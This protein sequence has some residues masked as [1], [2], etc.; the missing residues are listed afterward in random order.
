MS[1][2]TQS[3]WYTREMNT[4]TTGKHREGKYCPRCH[5]MTFRDREV[6]DHC[7]HRFRTG[8]EEPDLNAPIPDDAALH[9][10]MQFT[11]PPLP[12]RGGPA[13]D[14]IPDVLPPPRPRPRLGIAFAAALLLALLAGLAYF[15]HLK[16]MRPAAPSPAGV[17]ETTLA[18]R[19]D[20]AAH[21]RFDFRADGSG[22]FAWSANSAPP[23]AG[24]TALRWRA[25]PD[26][27]LA[28]TFAP[29]AAP[30]AFSH[31]LITSF[32]SRPWTWHV[33]R[34]RHRLLIGTWEFIEK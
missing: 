4:H 29:P 34:P 16:A 21:L 27:R 9:R 12:M 2:L 10:T 20:A 18:G 3:F 5:T 13:A 8:L 23:L 11:Q 14:I 7:G 17:W 30:D 22:Q 1:T 32:N 33:D 19:F 26:G 15:Q 24:Q 6:C 31:A 28:L 25:L